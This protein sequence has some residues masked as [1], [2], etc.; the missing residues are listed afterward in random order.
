[1]CQFVSYVSCFR[2]SLCYNILSYVSYVSYVLLT[3]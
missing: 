2:K 1:M 3:P